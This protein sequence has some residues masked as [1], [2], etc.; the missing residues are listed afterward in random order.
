MVMFSHLPVVLQCLFPRRLLPS[1]T[2]WNV[3]DLQQLRRG[4]E[5]HI[6]G[7]V[8]DGI[9]QASLVD[10]HGLESGALSFD[11]ASQTGGTG[12]DYDHVRRSICFF[13]DLRAWKSFWNLLAFA[14][15]LF[16]HQIVISDETSRIGLSASPCR[17]FF[18]GGQRLRK[19]Q[20]LACKESGTS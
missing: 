9:D 14:R 7:I 3:S 18:G 6:R 10:C 15:K 5:R 17:V 2:E 13:L 1:R 20:I 19:L 16:G 11:C 8:I 4:K 12:P